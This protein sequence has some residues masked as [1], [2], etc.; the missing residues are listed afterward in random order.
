MPNLPPGST[1]LMFVGIIVFTFLAFS[2][3]VWGI[4]P[5]EVEEE[6]IYG[7]RLTKRKRLIE[8][9]GLYALVLPMVQLFA[10][11]FSHLP[12]QFLGIDVVAKRENIRDRLIRSGYMGAFTPNEF[13]GMCCVAGLGIFG[14]FLFMTWLA[15]GFPNVP[16]ALIFGTAGVILPY[17]QL[18]TAIGERLVEIDRRLPYA[19]DLL[20]LSMRAGLDFMT[21]LDR[22]V[23]NGLEQNPDDPMVQELGVVLQEMRVGTARAD[24]LINLC[25][26]VKSD[27]LKSMVGSILQSEKRGT[28]LASVLEVQIGT[29]RNKRTQK[30][31]KAASE[32]AVKI[33]GPLM[34]IFAAVLVIV[35]GS[36]ILKIK[37]D[38]Q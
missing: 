14:V 5:D 15:Q 11:H 20:V 1:Q 37:T 24:A 7:Y 36:M 9:N 12:D 28:P 32:A 27:Y 23:T 19:I 2:L 29:I 13:W 4:V 31:E 33:L 22:V 30:I 18:D 21:A 26:R 35:I 17:L 38:T 6:D 10:H 8:E 34:F 16:V 25:E 3:F